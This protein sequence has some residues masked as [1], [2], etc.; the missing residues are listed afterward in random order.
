MM[1]GYGVKTEVLSDNCLRSTL[2]RLH[3]H[4]G[5]RLFAGLAQRIDA[6]AKSFHKGIRMKQCAAFWR[7]SS[8]VLP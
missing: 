3:D 4:D 1:L 2:D 6:S 8:H 5:K 7:T